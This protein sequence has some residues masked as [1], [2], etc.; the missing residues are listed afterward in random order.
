MIR[1]ALMALAALFIL[2][3]PVLADEAT[4]TVVTLSTVQGDI[5]VRFFPD[6]APE[7]VKNFIFHSREGNY[8]GTYF[9]RVIPGFM[10]QGGDF[11]TK[12]DIPG[13]DGTGG[14]SYRGPGT[15][16]PAEFNERKHLR[17]ILSMARSR[18]KDSAGSQ[19]FIMHA[20][21]KHLD[22][23]Y[24]VFGEVIDG[25]EVVDKIANAKCGARNRPLEN[26]T[27]LSVTV[28]EW[29]TESVEAAKAAMWEED[30][31]K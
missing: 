28:S 2:A 31:Q 23:Q 17:G 22:G 11:L 20:A 15:K 30:G 6:S 26:Q 13:N 12:D 5:V 27:I 3:F 4:E 9:H 18:D 16:L 8:T 25:I 14:Y 7:H 10:I 21:A 24:T 19:F 1:R 29:T